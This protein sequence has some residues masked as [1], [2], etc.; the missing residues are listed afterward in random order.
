MKHAC[1]TFDRLLRLR[2]NRARRVGAF[3]VAAALLS[4]LLSAVG[5]TNP[6]GALA[7]TSP[8]LMPA[9]GQFFPVAPTKVLD[10]R[11]GI[12]GVPAAPLAS[13]TTATFPVTGVGQIPA[14]DVSDVYVV[15]TAI[16]PQDNGCLQDYDS[17]LVNPA[18]CTV[19][20]AAREN[21]TDSD[22]VQVSSAGDVSVTN[23]SSG[24]A[25]V[26]V[27]VQGYYQRSGLVC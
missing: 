15:I 16:S 3:L 17:D 22:I 11:D 20:F 4:G 10:T 27:T 21:I 23:A 13:G 5:L 25:D 24:T 6:G 18:I 14:G 26:S 8:A 12:G 9:A 7:T 2:S 19:S 1:G